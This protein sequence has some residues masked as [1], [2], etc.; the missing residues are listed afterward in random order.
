VTPPQATR[1][2]KANVQ[3]TQKY[4]RLIWLN[5]VIIFKRCCTLAQAEYSLKKV[6]IK[7]NASSRGVLEVM[8]NKQLNQKR[9]RFKKCTWL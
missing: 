1:R 3:A 8:I 2:L 6:R 7:K 5:M 9:Y 4:K